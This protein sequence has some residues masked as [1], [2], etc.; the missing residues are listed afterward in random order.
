MMKTYNCVIEKCHIDV[1]NE[2][3]VR[4][5][6]NQNYFIFHTGKSIFTG[7]YKAIKSQLTNYFKLSGYERVERELDLIFKERRNFDVLIIFIFNMYAL[8]SADFD[9]CHAQINGVQTHMYVPS[10]CTF[11]YIYLIYHVVTHVR[12]QEGANQR[13]MEHD[14]SRGHKYT[15]NCS[16]HVP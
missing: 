1:L 8:I 14:I 4:N 7:V 11:S 12:Q 5:S 6:K 13:F 2:I 9:F 3:I 10:T 16:Y 15:G